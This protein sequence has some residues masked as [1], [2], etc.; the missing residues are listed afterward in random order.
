MRDSGASPDLGINLMMSWWK[1]N[2]NMFLLMEN[3]STN[4]KIYFK[5]FCKHAIVNR[6]KDAKK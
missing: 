4:N 1:L 2:F 3:L 5:Q 6:D